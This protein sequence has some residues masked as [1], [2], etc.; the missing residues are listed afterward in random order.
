[1]GAEKVSV[2]IEV[3]QH[4]RALLRDHGY[5]Y[6]AR[7]PSER[8]LAQTL[9]VSRQSIRESLKTLNLMGVVE[10][11]HGSGSQITS[12]GADILQTPFEFLLLIEQPDAEDVYEARE[13]IEVYCAQQAAKRRNDDDLASIEA[14][15]N[16][17]RSTPSD[18]PDPNIRF[19]EAVARASHNPV[20][21]SIMSSLSEG[22]RRCII[23]TREAVLDWQASLA[24]HEQI[25]VAIREQDSAAAR[26]AMQQHMAIAK[27]EL[28]R[29]RVLK[30]P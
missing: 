21:A 8:E 19:H 5:A 2:A 7:L 30:Q 22:L 9:N 20:L 6:G 23:E 15:L 11:R 10:T 16:E 14:A 27:D 3:M 12:S 13:L 1:V 18:T 28:E 25:F 17:M 24:I 4:M 29:V 26:N